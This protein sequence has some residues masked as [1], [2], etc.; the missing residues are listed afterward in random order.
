MYIKCWGARGSIPVSGEQYLKYGGD[1]TCMEIRTINDE[2][3]IVDA[4]TGIRRL[5]NKLIKEKSSKYNML[6]THAHWDHLMGFPFFKPIFSSKTRMNIIRCPHPGKYAEEMMTRVMSPPNF[7]IKYE[8]IKALITYEK[9]CPNG[10]FIDTLKIDPINLSHPNSG[11]GYKFTENDKTFVFLTDNELG[12]IH[13]WGKTLDEYVQ[14]SKN[15]DLLIHDCEY[16]DED[17][18]KRK[19]WGHSSVSQAAE[20]AKK[21]CVKKFGLFH[22]NQDKSDD[23]V[24]CLVDSVKELLKDT[25]TEVFGV[26]ADMEF[27]LA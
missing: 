24:E 11:C 25:D 13:P 7:P 22:H 10:F 2:I 16:S 23:D 8:D 6:F 18:K 26:K 19:E 14:F 5:G 12:H 3:I 17:Y 1:T 4:G 20:L 9:G 27:N 21:A 15:A